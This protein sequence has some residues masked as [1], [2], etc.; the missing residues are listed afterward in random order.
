VSSFTNSDGEVIE[1]TARHEEILAAGRNFEHSGGAVK[2]TKLQEF[3]TV[4]RY[5]DLALLKCKAENI[6]KVL[7]C[8][9]SSE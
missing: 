7:I 4:K 3:F 5:W 8:Y 9:Q 6:S 1:M 2:S